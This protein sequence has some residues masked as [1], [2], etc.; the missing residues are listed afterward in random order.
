MNYIDE[1]LKKGLIRESKSSAG[2]PV[3]FSPKP[4]GDLRM[5]IDYRHLN[6]ITKKNRF[7]SLLPDGLKD[8]L[9]GAKWFTKL[10]LR[11]GF[12][13]IRL[14]EGDE[15]KTAFCTKYSLYEYVVMLWGL[16]NAPATFQAFINNTLRENLDIFVTAYQDDILIYSKNQEEHLKHVMWVLEQLEEKKLKLKLNKCSFFKNEI[17]Y[18]GVIVSGTQMRM[19]PKRVEAVRSWPTP[20]GVKEV[21]SFLGFTNFNRKFIKGYSG[22]AAPLRDLTKKDILFEWT[23]KQEDAFNELKRRFMTEPILKMFDY[24]KPA[25][26]KCDASD[27]A[28]GG[29][30]SQ[31]DEDGKT[32]LVAYISRKL[33][34]VEQRYN[35]HDKELLAVV[36]CLTEWRH[37]LEGTEHLTTVYLDHKN[38]TYFTTTKELN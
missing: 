17:T 11:S 36:V 14:R 25:I 8:Q 24:E 20:E 5:C 35:I 10:D 27:Y 15:W 31:K 33:S 6:S 16:C 34:D 7:A 32:R 26:V 23:Q 28:V 29:V 4:D 9:A 1:H 19:D 38:L 22:I 3:L 37:Y 18:L 2:Y 21:Q 30:L 13:N 12:N